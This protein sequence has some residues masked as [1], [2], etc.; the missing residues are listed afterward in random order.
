VLDEAAIRDFLKT[1]LASYK[2]PRRLLFFDEAE[3]AKTGSDKVK[4]DALVQRA[5]ER[6]AR[7]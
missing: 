1:Q 3:I 5:V 7:G 2:V 6:L 4:A